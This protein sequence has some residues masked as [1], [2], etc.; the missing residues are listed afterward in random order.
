MSNDG[1]NSMP[2]GWCSATLGDLGAYINGRGFKKTEW[3]KEGRP[4]IRIQ[5]LTKTE[6]SAF[7]VKER[8][9]PHILPRVRDKNRQIRYHS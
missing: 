2:V 9:L 8:V 4:I 6:S 3:S 5:D 7:A 1:N